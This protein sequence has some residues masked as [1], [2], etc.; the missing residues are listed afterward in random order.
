VDALRRLLR[1]SPFPQARLHASYAIAS[2]TEPSVDD[3]KV[4]VRDPDPEVRRHGVKLAEPRLRDSNWRF[5]LNALTIDM[6]WNAIAPD[7]IAASVL[8]LRHDP[9]PNVRF[10]LA[11]SIGYAPEERGRQA[12]AKAPAGDSSGRSHGGPAALLA[13]GTVATL[14]AD[15]PWT[16]AAI[17]S[18]SAAIDGELTNNLIQNPPANRESA[19]GRLTLLRELSVTV[20]AADNPGSVLMVLLAVAKSANRDVSLAT[21]AGL[22]QG[23]ARRRQTI[24][25]RLRDLSPENRSR[26]EVQMD[27]AANLATSSDSDETARVQAIQLLAYLGWSRVNNSLLACLLPAQPRG[28]Q[29]AALRVLGSFPEAAVASALLNRWKQL[30]PPLRDQAITVLLSRPLWHEPLLA[31]LE[32]GDV[33]ISQVSIPQRSRLAASRDPKLA[34]RAKKVLASFAVGPRKDVIDRYQESLSLK[35]DGSRGQVVYRRECM[36]CHKLRGEGH[37]VG[38]SLET[39]QHRSPQEILIHVLDPNREVSPQFLDYTVRLNDGRVLTGLIAGE[40]DGGRTLRRAQAQEDNIPR[41]EIEDITSS[42]K[43]LMPEGVEQ[44][45]TPQEMADLIAYLRTSNQSAPALAPSPSPQP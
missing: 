10:Q 5:L 22:G 16:R 6:D 3:L 30:T 34:G 44:K 7:D 29:E 21:L 8:P 24:E 2:L 37:D 27:G 15:D 40:T 43:S 17:I 33:P 19:R 1:A 31:A 11:L 41:S 20:G 38:P 13:L 36:N 35:G 26:V 14:D 12:A 4:V 28:I 45:I 42:G 23:L 18:S 39:V 9:D 25:D 32:K